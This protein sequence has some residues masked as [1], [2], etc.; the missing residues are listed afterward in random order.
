MNRLH[1]ILARAL[2]VPLV[3]C[4]VAAAD[5]QRCTR[6]LEG[7]GNLTGDSSFPLRWQ[8]TSMTDGK[9]LLVSITEKD[10]AL[11][12]EFRKTQEGLWAEGAAVICRA[13]AG[14]EARVGQVRTGPAAHWILR[15]S[16]GRG[17]TFVLTR[18]AAAQ[19]H[20]ATPGWRGDFQARQD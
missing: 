14:L 20:I 16:L 10:G 17:S 6:T 1:P 4:G 7:L 3:F 9:P 12:L 8:E 18:P 15:Q 13:G 19:L 2:L 11:F 5:P